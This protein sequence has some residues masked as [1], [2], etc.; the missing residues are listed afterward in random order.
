MS[1][2]RKVNNKRKR[3]VLTIEDKLKV[4]E[5]VRQ[6]VPKPIIMDKFD[7]GKSTLIQTCQKEESFKDFKKKKPDLGIFLVV[8]TS[9]Q[10]KSGL[11]DQLESRSNTLH[12][13]ASRTRKGFTCHRTNSNGEG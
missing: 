3:V 4:C 10:I 12:L 1:S 7:I 8:K 5:M 11:F 6:N 9:K 2:C 13:V